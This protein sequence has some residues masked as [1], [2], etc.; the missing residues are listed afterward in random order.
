M[1]YKD[2]ARKRERDRRAYAATA[3]LR[4]RVSWWRGSKER[5][6]WNKEEQ[7]RTQAAVRPCAAHE[8]RPVGWW[9]TIGAYGQSLSF[10]TLADMVKAE[11]AT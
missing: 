5:E 10:N 4:Q 11:E 1:P 3:H 7:R 2:P 8:L 6:A 9:D